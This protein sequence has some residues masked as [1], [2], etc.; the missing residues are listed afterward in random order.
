MSSLSCRFC[1]QPLV[2][3]FADCGMT[4]MANAFIEPS[5]AD[6]MEPFYPLHAYVCGNCK[7]VQLASFESPQAIFSDY[8]YFSSFSQ[9]WLDHA[10]RYAARMTERFGLSAGSLVVEIASN[11]G[12]L[13]QYFAGRGIGVLGVDPAANVAAVA[14]E[15]GIQTEVAFFGAD[16]ARRLQARGVAPNLMTANNVLAHVPDLHDF[17]EGF[18]ILLAP[19]GVATFEFPHL[20][21]LMRHNQFDTIYH[22]HFSYLSLSMVERLFA[23]H[24]LVLFDAE[25]LPTHGGSLRI[26]LRHEANAAL[27]QGSAVARVR[28]DEIEAGLE[29]IETYRL[30]AKGVVDSKCALLEF[31]VDARQRGERVAAYGAPAKGNTLLN[32]CG[33]GPELI[34]FTVDRSPHKQ[35]LLLPGTRIPIRPPEAILEDKPD[36]VL[37]L[38]WNLRDEVV[39]QMSDIRSWGGRFVVPI[40]RVEVF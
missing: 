38:P 35:G 3:T 16:T 17:V 28:N 4:P 31:L 10:E 24:G 36:Y 11:D 29:R 18:R 37:I 40:P 8:L 23:E 26:F 20:L 34:A 5:A 15:K 7:L 12:Y 9:S 22:E 14:N 1:A 30:F 39:R 13:L 27:A 33:V 19:S 21:Q 6:R 25:E 32:Y 2:E